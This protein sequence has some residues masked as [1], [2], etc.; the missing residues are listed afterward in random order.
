MSKLSKKKQKELF[1]PK[2]LDDTLVNQLYKLVFSKRKSPRKY[3]LVGKNNLIMIDGSAQYSSSVDYHYILPTH[4]TRGDI[5]DSFSKFEFFVN[6]LIHIEIYKSIQ[7]SQD[8]LDNL[9]NRIDFFSKIKILKDEWKILHDEVFK[10]INK[11]KIVRDSMAH[12][13]NVESINY[14]GKSLKSNFRLFQQDILLAW[15]GLM[16]LYERK[17]DQNQLMKDTIKLLNDT[18]GRR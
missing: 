3:L 1:E 6:Y 7:N 16:V 9:L 5:L 11:L 18:N 2:G 10:I 17:I 15:K 8:K 12:H 4:C 14:D 13:W